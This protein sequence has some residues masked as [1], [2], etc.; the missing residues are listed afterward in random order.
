MKKALV[1]LILTLS[2]S[3]SAWA[4]LDSVGVFHRLDRVVVLINEN[5]STSR[6]SRMM[7]AMGAANSLQTLSVDGS[8]KI[9]CGRRAHAASCT[10]RFLPS[11]F[12][13]IGAK[14]SAVNLSSDDL[15]LSLAADY[16]MYFERSMQD[17]FSF[18]IHDNQIQ[19][20]AQKKP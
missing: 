14:N 4:S 6:L 7:D 17:K 13:K 20:V 8:V 3:L 1:F 16:E 9:E 5:S 19:I 18:S 12:V 2:N 15:Q 11:Q 10:F